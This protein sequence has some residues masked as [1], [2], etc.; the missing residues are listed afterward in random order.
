MGEGL[1]LVGIFMGNGGGGGSGEGLVEATCLIKVD[2]LSDFKISMLL[3]TSR[4]VI[5][6]VEVEDYEW[7]AGVVNEHKVGGK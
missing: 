1:V 5:L 3:T 6:A 4:F 2:R 7:I